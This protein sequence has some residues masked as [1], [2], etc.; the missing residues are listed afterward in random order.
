MQNYILNPTCIL[1]W[2][3][4]YIIRYE[5]Q[6]HGSQHAHIMLWIDKDDRDRMSNEIV[7]HILKKD[8]I[9]THSKN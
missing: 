5:I 9:E 3:E 1:G 8:S 7:M 2:I 6:N 4:Y